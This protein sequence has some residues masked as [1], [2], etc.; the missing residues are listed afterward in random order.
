M[1][2][3]SLEYINNPECHKELLEEAESIYSENKNLPYYTH[4]IIDEMKKLDNFIKETLRINKHHS[5][6][7]FQILTKFI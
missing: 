1:L 4:D 5:K 7:K 3:I 6:K 2:H